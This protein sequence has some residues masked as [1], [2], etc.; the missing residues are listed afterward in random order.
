MLSK[1]LRLHWPFTHTQLNKP[2][3]SEHWRQIRK[4]HCLRKLAYFY[5]SFLFLSNF[6]FLDVLVLNVSIQGRWPTLLQNLGLTLSWAGGWGWFPLYQSCLMARCSHE[7]Q[8]ASP[9]HRTCWT[10]S[11]EL[12]F[13]NSLLRLLPGWPEQPRLG[14][15]T[16]SVLNSVALFLPETSRTNIDWC[17]WIPK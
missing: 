15:P 6:L 5:Q 14:D 8:P 11:S 1:V 4:S 7:S 17:Q 2:R 16:S 10:A 3:K 13:R 12:P 9:Q